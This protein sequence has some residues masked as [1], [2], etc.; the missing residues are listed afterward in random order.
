MNK[1]PTISVVRLYNINLLNFLMN[2]TT[3]NSSPDAVKGGRPGSKTGTTAYRS[4][5]VDDTLTPINVFILIDH[6]FMTVANGM[7]DKE[8]YDAYI[9]FTRTILTVYHGKHC[10]DEIR[11]ALIIAKDHLSIIHEYIS[12]DCVV[13]VKFVGR[14]IDFLMQYIQSIADWF[15]A[16]GMAEKETVVT[17]SADK[18][19]TIYS[20]NFTGKFT[21]FV[22][23]VDSLLEYECFGSI[24]DGTYKD[25]T[26]IRIMLDLFGFGKKSVN[27]FRNARN[28]LFN[29]LPEGKGR[30]LFLP[31]IL[32]N[33]ENIWEQ[34]CLANKKKK[35]E[36]K[37]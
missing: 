11:S 24:N 21:E 29:K 15:A 10:K 37:A 12:N 9:S 5:N 2:T 1:H 28:K 22:E 34:K 13:A 32:T 35:P 8:I 16:H 30:C 19:S 4:T 7:S 25:S 36:K 33:I 3:S 27:D 18:P 17:K 31:Q 14:A 26:F 20:F 23:L 6:V